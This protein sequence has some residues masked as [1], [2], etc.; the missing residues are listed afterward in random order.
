[1]FLTAGI[2]VATMQALKSLTADPTQCFTFYDITR[3]A[4]SFTDEEIS[5]S[6]VQELVTA[7][8]EEGFM[9]NYDLTPHKF[10]VDGKTVS[11]QVF[12]TSC[13]DITNYQPNATRQVVASAN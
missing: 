3:T 13:G 5:H 2:V 7:F 8:L 10:T 4:R 9:H 12:H 6:Q 11:A 1:M